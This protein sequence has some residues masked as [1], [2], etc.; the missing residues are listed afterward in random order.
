[1]LEIEVGVVGGEEDGVVGAMDDKLYTTP[2]DALATVEALGLGENGRYMTALTFGNVHGVYK[3]GNVKLRPAILKTRRR[4][5]STSSAS[6]TTAEAVRPGLPRRVGLAAR[7]DP[8]GR[9]TT[10]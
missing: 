8:R 3:P 4:R 1:M 5:W 10:A 6:A 9:S 2:E 7:G